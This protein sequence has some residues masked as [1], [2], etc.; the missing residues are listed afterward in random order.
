MTS[1]VSSQTGRRWLEA[2]NPATMEYEPSTATISVRSVEEGAGVKGYGIVDLNAADIKPMQNAAERVQASDNAEVIPKPEFYTESIYKQLHG[3]AGTPPIQHLNSI[4]VPEM[5]TPPSAPS[6]AAFDDHQIVFVAIPN[7]SAP[8]PTE[9]QADMKIVEVQDVE[10]IVE[11]QD[12]EKIVEVQ[13]VEKIV[14]VQDVESPEPVSE[15]DGEAHDEISTLIDSIFQRFPLAASTVL[16]FVGTEENPHVDETCARVAS[17]IA[18]RNVGDVLL[19]DADLDGKRLTKASGLTGQTGYSECI[20]R[21]HQWRE[22][23]VSRNESSFGFLPA[24]NDGIDRW[25]AKQLLINSVAEMK[26]DYQF[27]CV[28]AGSAHSNHAKLWYDTC[29]GSYLVVS[30]KSSN[31]TIAKSSVNEL[32]AG[33]ARLLGCIVTDV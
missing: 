20:N 4:V 32:K 14:E 22:K 2:Q 21:S 29:D 13:D 12:V 27:V 19:V 25:N 28:S 8:S 16:L 23:I 18:S 17:A 5:N 11:V 7:V 26:N 24:G 6:N 31:E 30:L 9:V 10:K 1:T 3:A 15:A 33:G